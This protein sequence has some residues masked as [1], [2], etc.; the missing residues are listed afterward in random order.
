MDNPNIATV[1]LE[2]LKQRQIQ[3]CI[4]DF[5]TGYSSL[6][7]LQRFPAN[8]LK[9]DRSFVKQ[10]DLE[11]KTAAIMQIIMMLA[12]NLEMNVIAEGIETDRQ[13]WQLKALQCEYGQGYFF[14]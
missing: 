6:S 3:L 10:I 8:T 9:I 11:R 4:D 1:L 7:Y 5:G 2:Q 14:L 13:L 12:N